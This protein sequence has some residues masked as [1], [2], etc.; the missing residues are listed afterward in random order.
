MTPDDLVAT[1]RDVESVVLARAAR[2]HIEMRTMV[3]GRRVI[4]FR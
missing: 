1:G 3:Y 4:V 2:L